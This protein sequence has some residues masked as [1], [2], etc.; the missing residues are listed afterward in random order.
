MTKL[1][2]IHGRFRKGNFTYFGGRLKKIID[3]MC[4]IE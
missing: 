1:K 2:E 3:I 4:K